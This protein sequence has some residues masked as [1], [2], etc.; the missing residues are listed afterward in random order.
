MNRNVRN[1]GISAH[2][3]SGKTTLSERILFYTG[4][5]HAMHEVDGKDGVGATMDSMELEREKGISIQ[6]AASTCRWKDFDINLIDTPGHVDFTIEV[7]RAL[8]VLDGAILVLDSVAGVQS[9]SY[10]VDRQ[11]RRYKVPRI[12]FINKMDR[13]G[14]DAPRVVEM[15]REKLGHNPILLQMPLGSIEGVIDLIQQKGYL[16]EGENGEAVRE[17]EIPEVL[18]EE[19]SRRRLEIVEKCADLDDDV[20]HAYLAHEPVGNNALKRA[21]RKGCLELKATP[22]FLG[23]AYR[24]IGVQLLL[25][26]VVDYLPGPDEVRIAAFDREGKEIELAS[27]PERPLVALAFKLQDGR[28]GQLTYVRIYQGRISKGDTVVNC[29]RGE[30][31][32]KVPRLVRMHADEMEDIASGEAGDIVAVFGV[33]CS[34]GDTFTAEGFFCT[35]TPLHVP[36]PVMSLAV[37]PKAASENFSKAIERFRREDPTLG[38]KFD[39]ESGQMIL[40]GM[41]ELHLE[42]YLERIRREYGCEVEAGAP[43]VAYRETITRV[44]SFNYTHKKQTGGKG[45]YA[46]VMGRIEPIA[47]GGFEFVDETRGGAIPEEFMSAVE[48][49]FRDA[50]R[51]GSLIGAPIVGVRV[52]VDNG[53]SHP[54]DS[55]E[56]AFSTA[57][58]MA[59]RE[60]YPA[61]KPRILQP[62]M[63]VEAQAP[64]EFQG[65]LLALVRRRGGDVAST[66]S[67][68]DETVVHVDVPLAHMFGFSTDLRSCT[69]GKGSFTMEFER[70][71]LVPAE[72]AAELLAAFHRR[73]PARA[74]P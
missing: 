62:I 17:A 11:M 52:V 43:Q 16:F 63:R 6:A 15:L 41:G 23:S 36:D 12:A 19:A 42:I 5:I 10:T 55:S 28:F 35:L 69:Q 38:A 68:G 29:A 7:E 49:G 40:S 51:K 20:A 48:K 50:V 74:A 60:A 9:Q 34:T 59:F 30:R 8:R 31:R 3:D 37:A 57:A 58:V 72:E 21:I 45:Q 71:D 73:V 22:V 44:A 2:I 18:R 33:E 65:V 27:D 4:R 53:N 13:V 46:K 39:E 26:G 56:L 24:N 32:V 25:D 64:S 66:D 70:Y 54:V 47:G 61:A 14:A 1:I 67:A